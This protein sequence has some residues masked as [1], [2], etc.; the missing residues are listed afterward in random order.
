MA[1]VG[2]VA[3]AQRAV[4]ELRSRGARFA[5]IGGFAVSVR[6]EPRFTRDLDLAL[7]VGSDAEAERLLQACNRLA[8]SS[9]RWSSRR[10]PG[11]S[12]PPACARRALAANRWSST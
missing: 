3:F 9:S 1:E 12:Q 4:S 7:A 2:L 8:T 5:V 11:G 10:P 6:T